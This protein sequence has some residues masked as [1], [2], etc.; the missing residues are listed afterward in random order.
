MQCSIAILSVT[1]THGQL[2]SLAGFVA[3]QA[4]WVATVGTNQ[5]TRIA[6]A[7]GVVQAVA[8]GDSIATAMAIAIT[9]ATATAPF[10]AQPP[11]V[12]ATYMPQR[13]ILWTMTATST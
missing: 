13:T 2:V 10:V 7:E 3:R 5:E 4:T 9:T 12:G 11:F 6:A 8:E 1:A